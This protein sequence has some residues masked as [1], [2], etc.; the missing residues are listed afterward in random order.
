MAEDFDNH[1][2]IF[3]RGDD[4]QGAAAIRA[5]LHVDV[6]GVVSEKPIFHQL[7]DRVGESQARPLIV[8]WRGDLPAR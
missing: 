2:R 8:V 3:D 5:V 7:T 4:L 1:R 6:D